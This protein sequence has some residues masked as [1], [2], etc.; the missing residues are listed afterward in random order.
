MGVNCPAVQAYVLLRLDAVDPTGC[1]I[2]V[3]LPVLANEKNRLDW[4]HMVYQDV[5]QQ[6]H[7]LQCD[8]LVILE[9]VKGKTL[10]PLP[11]GSEKMEFA[12]SKSETVLDSIDKSVIYAIESAVIK[13]SYQVQ[14]VL[15]RESSQPLL[16][17]ENPTPKAELE[18]WKN[19]YEDLK[20]IYHQ[21]R[22]I[23]VRG[24]ARL[25]D[26]LQSSYFPAF[27]AMYRDVVA[28]L[29]EAQDIYVHLKP[30]QRHLETLENA[31]FP[32]VKSR[33]RPLLHVVCLIWAMCNCYRSPGRLT[34]LLQEICNLLIQ[35]ASNYLSPEDLLK[36]EVEESQ[37]KLQVVSDTL[38]FFKQVFQDR[39]ENLHT[40]FKE[41]RE[42]KE[43]D[44]QSSLVFVRLDS[45]LGRLHTVETES[46][47]ATQAG[48]QCP[49]LS[50]LQSLPP[51]FKQFSCLSLLIEMGFHHVG[52]D[53]LDLLIS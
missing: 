19:R 16:Q 21:L 45:F 22:T 29:A 50:S 3:V 1:E 37:R 41:N 36:S 34:V 14:V 6:A 9:Q 17:G 31:E 46:H 27:K 18:F 13:W 20:F 25:L 42:V 32:E 35:Q 26:K 52:Q 2:R 44:F 8:L 5:R 33:L 38:S 7:S 12:D 24:M 39:R 11:A 28:A 53:S 23:K 40:Y 10:L 15:K 4:P 43:W 47:S 49:S 48:V 30:L 51:V